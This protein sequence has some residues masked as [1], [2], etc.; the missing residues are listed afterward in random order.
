MRKFYILLKKEIRELLT[1]QIIAPLVLTAVLFIAIGGILGKEQKKAQAPQEVL[2]QNLDKGALSQT[3]ANILDSANLKTETID[4]SVSLDNALNQAREGNKIALLVI[5]ADF[6]NKLLAPDQKSIEVYTIIRGFS[7]TSGQKYNAVV[8]A[9]EL[10]N[11]GISNILL[12][13]N[14]PTVNPD[15][16]K[17][18]VRVND[19]LVVGGKKAN[20]NPALVMGFVTQQTMFIPI[21]LFFV[22]VFA[23]QMIATAIATEKENKTLETLLTTPVD[24]R[25]IVISK[26]TAAGIVALLA[27]LIYLYGFRSYMQGITGGQV[28]SAVVEAIK[29]LGL[30]FTPLGYVLLGISLFVGIL[31]ALSIALILGAFAEDIKSVAGLTAPLMVLVAIPYFLTLFLDVNSLSPILRYITY[32]I[33]FSHIFLAAPNIFLGNYLAVVWGI[34]YQLVFF[35]VFAML[36][37]KIFSTDLIM[38]LKLNFGKKK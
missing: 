25:L 18:P 28:I 7:I 30:T 38:T 35:L 34:L 14:L 27:S 32:A 26:M 11:R 16:I 8:S 12:A 6:E 2:L 21:I 24:R 33:P 10:M 22:I 36:A 17:S 5:P 3:A 20:I 4:P 9:V 37:A 15:L 29:A 31:A 1:L 23:S 19:F 13:K